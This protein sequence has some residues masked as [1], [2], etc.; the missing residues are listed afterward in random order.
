MSE[1]DESESE[2]IDFENLS[3]EQKEMLSSN[4]DIRRMLEYSDSAIPQAV[5][6]IRKLQSQDEFEMEGSKNV[7]S[8]GTYSL[9]VE[10][11]A[12]RAGRT[13]PSTVHKVLN[14]LVEEYEE[15]G[16]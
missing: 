7:L 14:G 1:N 8:E 10:G 11:I 5:D 6:A 4:P 2:S 16:N 9:L 15:T 3:A 12:E 13:T